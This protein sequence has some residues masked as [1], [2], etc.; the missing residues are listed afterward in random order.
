MAIVG[1][2]TVILF[3]N[4]NAMGTHTVNMSPSNVA[5]QTGLDYTSGSGVHKV[6]IV[7]FRFRPAV[8][9]PEEVVNFG[10]HWLN[11][12]NT[13]FA[14]RLTSITFGVANGSGSLTAFAN[15]FWWG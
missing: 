11:W 14:D 8:D 13:I 5:A 2:G 15:I 12:P 4:G 1:M 3:A 10:D 6:G 7:G 9:G